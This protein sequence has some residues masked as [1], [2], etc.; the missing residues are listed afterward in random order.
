MSQDSPQTP[1]K[2]PSRTPPRDPGVPGTPLEW[3]AGTGA[4]LVELAL[5]G[6]AAV[7]TR[8]LVG[9]GLGWVAGLASAVVVVAIWATWMGPR[10][11]RR[12]PL[13]GRLVLGCGLVVL[14]AA[15]AHTAGL[16]SWAWW[17]GGV[18]LLL[19]VAGQA[20]TPPN[21]PR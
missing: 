2:A 7:A 4:F 20:L 9:G 14:A 15:L 10:S 21:P 8:L 16:T 3:A 18:G 5:V 13:A 6:T 17:F 12:L 11:N 1:S 19:T